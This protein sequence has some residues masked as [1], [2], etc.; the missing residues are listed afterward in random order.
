VDTALKAS[1]PENEGMDFSNTMNRDQNL[2]NGEVPDFH[3]DRRGKLP[4]VRALQGIDFKVKLNKGI[5]GSA[6]RLANG[7][8][9]PAADSM[10]M[11]A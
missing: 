11:T 4:S 9:L 7:E 2:V 6:E 5:W 1:R 8:T 10:A 3:R